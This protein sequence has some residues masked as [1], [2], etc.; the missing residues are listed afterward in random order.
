MAQ[1][2]NDNDLHGNVTDDYLRTTDTVSRPM[3]LVYTLLIVFVVGALAF[4][5]FLGGR[6]LYQNLDGSNESQTVEVVEN[7][8]TTTPP[9]AASTTN[10]S[11]E[12]NNTASPA[13]N[14]GTASSV[15]QNTSSATASS[16]S[17][18]VPATGAAKPE[19]IPATG[20][21][22]TI[23]IFVVVVIFA[24]ATHNILLRRSTNH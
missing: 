1:Y 21:V 10:G 7:P 24:T 20:A 11:N 16:S 8:I 18:S 17:S 5:I 14:A 19:S 13:S 23:M 15:A 22:D 4:S 2:K 6:W 9:T 12:S 3:A